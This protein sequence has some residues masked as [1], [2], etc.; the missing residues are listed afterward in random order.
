MNW[1][2]FKNP[3]ALTRR[4]RSSWMSPLLAAA[5]VW[6]G[7]AVEAFAQGSVP[8]DR[9]ALGVLY[10]S[11]GGADW[12]DSTNWKTSAPLDEWYGVSTDAAGRVTGLNLAGNGLTGSVPAALGD[13]GSLRRLDL[14]SRWDPTLRQFLYNALTGPIPG[15]L[16]SLS[17]L[18]QLN[19]YENELTGSIPGE[20]GSLSNLRDLNLARNA[21]TGPIPDAVGSLASL[22]SLTLSANELTGP[23]PDELGSLANLNALNLGFNRLTGTISGEL[24]N[25]VNLRV[26]DLGVN[27]LTGQIP[28]ELGNLVNLRRLNLGGNRLTGPI[29]EELGNL[30]NLENLTLSSNELTGPI[31]HKLGNLVKLEILQLYGNDLTGQIPEE[32]ARLANLRRL[33]LRR[34]ALSGR[35]P[36][37]LGN[38][39]NL[40]QLLLD[41][42]N[43]VGPIPEELGNL[44]NLD[45]LSLSRNALTGRIPARLG[46]LTRLG[47]FKLEKNDLSGQ[48]PGE[49]GRLTNLRSL[50]LDGNWGLKG[51]VPTGLESSRLER[52]D[53][54]LTQACAPPELQDW[55]ETIEFLGQ[56]C[57]SEADVT[58][59]VAVVY[60]P[61]AR[62]VAGGAA[63]IE[64]L[65]DLMIAETNDAYAASD[66]R[67]RLALVER[68]EVA[69]VET[70]TSA[71]DLGR[72]AHPDDGHMDGVHA[73]RD[74]SGADL[75]HLIVQTSNVCGQADQP[76]FVS[77]SL[78]GCGGL[79]FAHELGHNQGLAHDRYQA[80]NNEGG[81]HLH[82]AYGYVNQRAFAPGATRSSRW[83]TIMAYNAQCSASG[84]NCK[85][86]PRF[87]NSRQTYNGDPLGVPHGTG[88]K[89]MTGP[90]DAAAVLNVAG[91][92]VAAWRDRQL[93]ANQPPTAARTL[94]DRRLPG[95]SSVLELDVS[96]AFVD[97]ERD[98]LSY[99]V[100]SSAPDVATVLAT[101]RRVMLTAVGVGASRILVTAT[102]PGGLSATQLFTVTVTEAGAEGVPFTDDPIVPGETPVKEVHFTELRLRIDAVRTAVG[103]PAFAWTD[104][105]LS[106]GV[107]PIRLVHLLELRSALA[108]AYAES[109]RAAP[110]YTDAA[111][112][113]GT[114]PIRAVHL[115]ELREAVVALE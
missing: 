21:L 11:T 89:G 104:R 12:R 32:L 47:E 87:S 103:L 31:L 76:G 33:D 43:F 6:A 105:V 73:L 57:G 53:L 102:D 62:K 108:A 44:T 106:A 2:I 9:T 61:A 5:A 55:L 27:D 86:V 24:G 42:N 100:Y 72:L 10:D 20:L 25:L 93:G 113:A 23:A 40:A 111:P 22:E 64:A 110:A 39:A 101:G 92:A 96:H 37:S 115:M 79:V 66:V 114:T 98:V 63:A 51:P 68:S 4:Y 88:E 38:P 97:P 81:V 17:N 112:A 91:R 82:P 29:P 3:S 1:A 19:L 35:I 60:T 84:F 71:I 36:A 56:V 26:L 70:G 80:H 50:A 99:A 52:L 107:T 8:L 13:L 54:F 41:D 83:R 48:I 49:L 85:W 109:G 16:G 78:R 65:I 7:L 28:G 94:P 67:H 14:G 75:V 18:E 45:S 30:V 69:Y 95:L 34:N 59:D 74:R 90:S 77:I 15:E 46:N 58:I